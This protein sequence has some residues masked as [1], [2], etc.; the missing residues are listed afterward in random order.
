MSQLFN[1][2]LIPGF[3]MMDFSAAAEPLRSANRMGGDLY[4]WRTLS[5]DGQPVP[6]SNGMSIAVDASL[7]DL[8]KDEMLFVVAAYEPLAS[9]KPELAP[10]LKRQ[11]RAG[12][13]L[14]GID[15]G[16]FVLAQAGLM[17]GYRMTVHW[18]AIDSLIESYPDLDVRHELF[19]IDRR[20]ITS[21]GGTSSM[22]LML[23]LIAQGHGRALAQRVS[24]QFIHARIRPR[25][26]SQ[27]DAVMQ[28]YTVENPKLQAVI[29]RIEL[30]IDKAIDVQ[31]LAHGVGITRRQ[32]ERLFR[33]YL[34][35]SPGAFRQRLRLDKARHLLQQSELSILQISIACGFESP[36]YFGRCYRE[37]FKR[38]PRQDRAVLT[39]HVDPN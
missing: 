10:W 25:S 6:A 8:H 17:R 36:S 1:F 26:D 19:E 31:E 27:R 30:S 14:G 11:D 24:E 21:A 4:R 2:L 38:T 39:G 33:T 3:S 9:I 32:L 37:H 7:V 35:Q 34:D 22:D 16:T 23:E 12:V 5:Q 13:T 28:R 29:E 15:T 20:R 18:E